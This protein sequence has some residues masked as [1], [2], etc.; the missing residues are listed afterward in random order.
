MDPGPHPDLH[1][2]GTGVDERLC[3]RAG[4]DVAADDL[5]VPGRRIGLDAR[6]HLE[7]QLD[8][9]V[10][11][12]GHQHVD[13]RV[14]E[15]RRPLPRVAE[16][17]DRPGD[18]QPA[19]GVLGGLRELL[20][21]HE[22]L[23]RDEAGEPA[24]LVDE[25]EPLALVLPQDRG[26]VV[27]RD[28]DGR[29]DQRHRRHDL[30]DL[31]G[32]PLGD[33]HEAQVAVGDH[34]EQPLVDVDDRQPGDPVAAADLVELLER[35]VGPDRHRV[36]DPTGLG[37][38]HQVDLVRLVGDGQVA[39]Q[40][41]DAA[42]PGHGDRHPRLGHGVHRRRQQR[43]ADGQLTGEARAGV[44]LGRDQVALAGQQQDVVEGQT[45]RGRTARASRRAGF[46]SQQRHLRGSEGGGPAGSGSGRLH[47]GPAGSQHSRRSAVPRCA[48]DVHRAGLPA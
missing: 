3:A 13:A 27:G 32:R 1:G 12:V 43:H 25:R 31:G 34:A 46:H 17:A 21:L 23:D 24:P 47:P 6:D 41:P 33:R 29:R 26:R 39:V 36:G 18:Q 5:D 10:G 2:V 38:L 37:P 44:D 9:A 16:V 4:R 20:G 7:Q 11:G 8:V 15:G 19:V 22:V 48:R 40:H 42:L 14:D 45:Q 30:V 35:R 28:V